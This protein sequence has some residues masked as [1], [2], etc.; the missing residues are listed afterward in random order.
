MTAVQTMELADRIAN[1]PACM[2]ADPNGF[3]S[4]H[5]SLAERT[6]IVVALRN[7]GG[8]AGKPIR[9]LITWSDG[10]ES[11]YISEPPRI[12]GT[13]IQPLYALP[14]QPVQPAGKG[15][16]VAWRWRHP[17]AKCWIYDPT[18]EWVEQHKHEIE[19]EPLY[20]LPARPEAPAGV[21]EALE[22]AEQVLSCAPFS[23]QIWPNGMH[24][25][26]G[27]KQIRAALASLPSSEQ[28]TKND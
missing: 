12:T 25:N 20:D 8:N 14:S 24:P 15:E 22:L 4:L 5:L 23:T 6:A 7:H 19:L 26:E 27:I 1:E 13:T 18:P 17:E 2:P 3:V 11:T 21:R 10:A 9:W 16:P 28:D